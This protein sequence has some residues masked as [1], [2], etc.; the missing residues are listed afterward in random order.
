MRTPACLRR[1]RCSGFCWLR[2][3]SGWRWAGVVQ[4][5]S[6][7]RCFRRASRV[8]GP[9]CVWV[10]W[11]WPDSGGFGDT[12]TLFGPHARQAPVPARD[13]DAFW[14]K[15]PP[16]PR[17][18]PRLRR[19]LDHRTTEAPDYNATRRLDHEQRGLPVAV[20]AR[21][22]EGMGAGQLY[23]V[24]PPGRFRTAP[25]PSPARICIIG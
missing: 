3:E 19:F 20:G 22:G 6:G 12:Q 1:F 11:F 23:S 14:T 21:Q 10:W 2:R 24:P 5:A 16:S 4:N 8:G 13:L 18:R 15:C 25:W 7:F 9:K 17:S